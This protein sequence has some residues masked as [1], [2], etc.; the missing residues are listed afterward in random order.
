M[1]ENI[2]LPRLKLLISRWHY[3]QPSKMKMAVIN[4]IK[5]RDRGGNKRAHQIDLSVAASSDRIKHFLA[6][7]R[8]K[9]RHL[10]VQASLFHLH[11]QTKHQP[12]DKR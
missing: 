2:T 5:E 9:R 6:I 8:L 12:E 1:V 7:V 10:E 3:G 11:L 4:Q